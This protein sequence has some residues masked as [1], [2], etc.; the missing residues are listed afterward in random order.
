MHTTHL[1]I[2]SLWCSL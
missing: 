2:Y 1:S